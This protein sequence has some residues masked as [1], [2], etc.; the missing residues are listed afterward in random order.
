[1]KMLTSILSLFVCMI[2]GTT[3][4]AEDSL[5]NA[6]SISTPETLKALEAQG[7]SLNDMINPGQSLGIVGNSQLSKTNFKV[8]LDNLKSEVSVYQKNNPKAGVGMSFDQRLFDL[9][10]LAHERARFV[11]V[12]IINRMDLGY[13][14]PNHCG[15]IRFIYRLAYNVESQGVNVASRLPMT[16]NLLLHQGSSSQCQAIAQRWQSI[17]TDSTAQDLLT[18]GPLSPQVFNRSWLK[19]LEINMQI[20]RMAASERPDFGGHAEYL[21]KAYEWTGKSFVET[22]LENQIDR[23]KLQADPS[24]MAELTEWISVPQNIKAIDDG[25]MILPKKFLATN[26]IS[27]APGGINRSGNR[28]FYGLLPSSATDIVKTQSLENI[29]SSTALLRRLNES[30]CIGCHQ[31]R[32]IGGFHFTGRDPQGKYAGNSVFLPGSAHFMGDLARRRQIVDAFARN[33]AIDYSRGFAA[34]PQERRSQ[35]LQGTGLMNG[36]GAH[37]STG[38]D[39]S[40]SKWTCASGFVCKTLLEKE[41]SLGLGICMAET[42]Q[43]GDPC[44]MGKIVTT[45]FGNDKYIRTSDKLT[46]TLPN[47]MCSPQSQA[48]GTR[49]G[50]FLNGNVRTLSC[51]NLPAEA[52]CGPLP[53]ARPGFNAC[54][55]TKNFDACLKEFSLGVGLRGCDQFNP[56]RDDY[57]CAES[58]EKDRG[59]C[60]PPYFLFQFRVDGHPKKAVAPISQSN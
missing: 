47:A 28:L 39:P 10:Y 3:A 60:V 25:T 31:T 26:G 18:T 53:A 40:F 13:K 4:H 49:T 2:M 38:K 7:F 35:R 14:N 57:I 58:F 37:C 56:C 54:I 20:S 24:L 21:L 6:L 43:V 8:I 19:D 52:S 17:T 5:E 29:K 1:M 45:S 46:V 33:E 48:P 41:D 36:W 32:A 59:S 51:D 12:G 34:R 30:T 22:T 15:E 42:Q 23:N 11:L 16:I 9:N 44:E 27:I 50:G 55:G